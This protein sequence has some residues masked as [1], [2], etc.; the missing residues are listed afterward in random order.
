MKTEQERRARLRCANRSRSRAGFALSA[1][2]VVTSA[3]V[4]GLWALLGDR[5]ANAALATGA[6]SPIS[7]E[8]RIQPPE[9]GVT[10]DRLERS[11]DGSPVLT[12]LDHVRRQRPRPEG[13]D[14]ATRGA[15]A[16]RDRV[17]SS[18][19]RLLV[20]GRVP[21]LPRA[22]NKPPAMDSGG[23][24]PDRAFTPDEAEAY[25]AAMGIER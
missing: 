14:L 5:I 11:A 20:P 24:N 8:L 18:Y 16:R 19:D 22:A 10:I 3:G 4:I 6:E 9:P 7:E 13:P 25:L 12:G 17:L 23:A 2:F 1:A 15:E 21:E